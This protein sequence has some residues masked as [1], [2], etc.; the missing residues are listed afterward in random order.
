MYKKTSY[1]SAVSSID[2]RV[3]DHL[4]RVRDIPAA[5]FYSF[6]VGVIAVT[7]VLRGVRYQASPPAVVVVV[8]RSSTHWLLLYAA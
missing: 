8:A 2:S 7:R 6:D 5:H 4:C 3:D 1:T